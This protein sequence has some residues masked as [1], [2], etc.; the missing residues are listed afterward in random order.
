[1]PGLCH[2][3]HERTLINNTVQHGLLQVQ[4]DRAGRARVLRFAGL[5][6]AFKHKTRPEVVLGRVSKV[7]HPAQAQQPRTG[8]NHEQAGWLADVQIKVCRGSVL[9]LGGDGGHVVSERGVAV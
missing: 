8:L 1:M 3:A 7:F 9:R 6:Q 5:G 2:T 4:E